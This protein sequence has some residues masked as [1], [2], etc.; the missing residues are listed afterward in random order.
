MLF[1]TQQMSVMFLLAVLRILSFKG[2]GGSPSGV[3]VRDELNGDRVYHRSLPDEWVCQI[4][5]S[6]MT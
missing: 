2:S 4:C 3:N 5:E 6:I 1:V